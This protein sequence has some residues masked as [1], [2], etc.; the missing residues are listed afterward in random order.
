MLT[1]ACHRGASQVAKSGVHRFT[2][3]TSVRELKLRA[4]NASDYQE[5]IAAV[6]PFAASFQELESEREEPPPS[7]RGARAGAA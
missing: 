1:H 3:R 7:A 4:L 5:W 2:V 6:R